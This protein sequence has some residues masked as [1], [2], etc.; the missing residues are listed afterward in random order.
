MLFCAAKITRCG[1]MYCWPC[2]LHYLSLSDKAWRKCPICY[3]SIYKDDLKRYDRS[4]LYQFTVP[5]IVLQQCRASSMQLG[6]LSLFG[7]W[8]GKRY[9]SLPVNIMLHLLYRM[10]LLCHRNLVH[11]AKPHCPALMV[12]VLCA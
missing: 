4:N 1:H 9:K 2:L 8:P 7:L 6:T 10:E 12:S 5:S 11:P 3:E